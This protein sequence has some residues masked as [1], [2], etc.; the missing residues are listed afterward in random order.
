[1]L[2]PFAQNL[3]KKELDISFWYL[4]LK[5]AFVWL[6]K[7]EMKQPQKHRAG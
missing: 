2:N 1:M 6:L 4:E 7:Q 3:K 5:H